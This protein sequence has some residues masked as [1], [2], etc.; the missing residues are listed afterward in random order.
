[1]RRLTRGLGPILAL[2]LLAAPCAADVIGSRPGGNASRERT[3]VVRRLESL[4]LHPVQARSEASELSARDLEY[5]AAQPARIALAGAQEG[6][7][8]GEL[9][10]GSST[11]LWYEI[12]GG[13]LMLGGGAFLIWNAFRH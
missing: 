9:L 1:M 4:G 13:V 11:V 8:Q 10:S 12:V 2:L 5:F 7:G 6:G 3:Q